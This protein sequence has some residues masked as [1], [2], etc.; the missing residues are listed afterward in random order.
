GSL[1]SFSEQGQDLIPVTAHTAIGRIGIFDAR[2]CLKS[3]RRLGSPVPSFMNSSRPFVTMA[4]VSAFVWTLIRCSPA[5]STT[6]VPSADVALAHAETN[7]Y[8]K[9][10]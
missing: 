7:Y 6:T 10:A 8:K 1:R 5:L 9:K 4:I 2:H 3:I